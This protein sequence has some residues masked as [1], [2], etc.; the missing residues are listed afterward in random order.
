MKKYI[1]EVVFSSESCKS[2]WLFKKIHIKCVSQNWNAKL[3]ICMLLQKSHYNAFCW[4]Y[5]QK[6][7]A[8]AQSHFFIEK[9][10]DL[11]WDNAAIKVTLSE[12]MQHF[13]FELFTPS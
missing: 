1:F 10:Q 11:F 2:I 8:G 3:S 13:S 4:Q 5:R 9:Y 12:V 7:L 6:F